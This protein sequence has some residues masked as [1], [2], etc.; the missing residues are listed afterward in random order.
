MKNKLQID[1]RQL[2]GYYAVIRNADGH[3]YLQISSLSGSADMARANAL[4]TNRTAGEG[5]ARANPI[6]GLAR[7]NIIIDEVTP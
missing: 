1:T 3:N 5:W 7:V 2:T 6:V 4:E